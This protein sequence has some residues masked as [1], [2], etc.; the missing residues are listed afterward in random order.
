MK[1]IEGQNNFT[2]ECDTYL[3]Y[4]KD[5]ADFHVERDI[6]TYILLDSVDIQDGI[7]VFRFL[8]VPLE[9]VFDLMKT[10]SLQKSN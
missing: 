5:M 4:S 10:I 1:Q 9:D 6:H 3:N 8:G 2:R 7:L